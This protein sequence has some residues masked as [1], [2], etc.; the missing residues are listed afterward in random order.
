MASSKLA[1][2][3]AATT[4][5]EAPTR[6]AAEAFLQHAAAQPGF[7]LAA[8]QVAASGAEEGVRLAAAVAFK[9]HVKFRWDPAL[10]P[11][12]QA[13]AALPVSVSA[14]EKEQIKVALVSVMLQQPAR[15]LAQ[16]GEA[17]ALIASFDFPARWPTLLPELVGQLRAPEPGVVNGVLVSMEAIFRRFREHYKTVELVSDIKYV[18]G[19]LAGPLLELL[20]ATGVRLGGAEGGAAATARPL[21]TTVLHICRIFYS[22]NYQDLPG[23]LQRA[24]SARAVRC[25]YVRTQRCLRTTWRPGWPSSSAT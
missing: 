2:A 21:L 18:L 16:L 8:L 23:E 7:G 14:A 22:L 12:E 5:L 9:N 15:I 10:P 3:F 13:A 11:P 20:V 1:A 24:R 17:L 6:Q 4:A 25:A 19:L